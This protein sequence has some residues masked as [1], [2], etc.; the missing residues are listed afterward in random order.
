[1]NVMA[2][3]SR[4]APAL[5][6][7]QDV[8]KQWH[9]YLTEVLD[10]SVR[11]TQE[12]PVG[13]VLDMHRFREEL[14]GFDF[15][16]PRPLGELLPWTIEQMEH[17]VVHQ[18]PPRYFGLFNPCPAFPA[19]CAERIVAAFNPQLA[20]ATTSPAA[21]EIEAHVIR[22]I[23]ERSGFPP[24]SAGHFTTGGSEANCTALICALTQASPRFAAEGA[25]AFAGQPILY[26]SEDAHLAWYKI[27]HQTGIGRS[28][29][30]LIRTDETGRMDARALA[31]AVFADRA[32]GCVPVM[33]VATA[34]TTG[35]GMIDPVTDCLEIARGCG[36]WL[37]VDAAWG[38]ALIASDRLRGLLAGMELA[39]STTIDAHKW[40]AT[41]M[42]CGMFITRHAEILSD[43]FHVAVTFMPSSVRHLDPYLTTVQWSRRFIGLR[44]F[45]SLAAAGWDGYADHVER[46][47][48]LAELL[49][50]ELTGSGWTV[51]N[52]SPLGVVCADP[53]EGSPS[54]SSIAHTLVASGA[55][56]VS[57]TSFRGRD[58]VRMCVTNGQTMPHD[59]LALVDSLQGIAP[60]S[61]MRR[62]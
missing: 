10:E 34:G 7:G 36:A 42:A 5:F 25:R 23:A 62:E 4:P 57:S 8:R 46:T 24:G 11:R 28:S 9:E 54:P 16:A 14:T 47:V 51:A 48:Q 27:A 37:H 56:W 15:R 38:G 41:T 50:R 19:E 52:N 32:Q 53:P 31:D 3:Q 55:A 40:L 21:V 60:S 33:I 43:A 22:A 26:V 58:V 59:I 13:P 35:A 44:L 61:D 29:V 49:K 20:S 39:D 45:L 12:G 18:I 17:G 1:M 30:R 6:P 2:A